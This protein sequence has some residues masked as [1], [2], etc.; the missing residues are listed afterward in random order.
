[1]N[2]EKAKSAYDSY[3]N[4]HCTKHNYI[5]SESAYQD[6]ILIL[7]DLR[8]RMERSA[9]EEGKTIPVIIWPKK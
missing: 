1:M 4:T 7:K 8:K 9:E 2:Y 5:A 6:S 3:F